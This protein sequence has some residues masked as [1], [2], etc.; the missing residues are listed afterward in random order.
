MYNY[1]F[2]TELK[3][4]AWMLIATARSFTYSYKKHGDGTSTIT[5]LCNVSPDDM[6]KAANGSLFIYF[7]VDEKAQNIQS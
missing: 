1:I 3:A 6:L 7:K 2:H 5:C 4:V